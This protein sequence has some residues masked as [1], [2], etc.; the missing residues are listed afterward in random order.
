MK[1]TV[2]QSELLAALTVASKGLSK[3]ASETIL[4]NS[5][6]IRAETDAITIQATDLTKAISFTVPAIVEED[7]GAIFPAA[8]INGIA[9]KLPDASIKI[10]TNTDDS[11]YLT[12]DTIVYDIK[13][14]DARDFPAFP[15]VEPTQ[16]ISLPYPVFTTM[17]K[18]VLPATGKDETRQLLTGVLIEVENK[19]LKMVATD[20]FRLAV[21]E[22]SLPD[23]EGDDYHVVIAGE[24]LKELTALP[25]SEEPI[26]IGITENQVVIRHQKSVFVNRR[27][28]GN[29]PNYKMLLQNEFST[30]VIINRDEFNAALGRVSIVSNS[31]SAAHIVMDADGNIMQVASLGQEKGSAQQ[32]INC[33]IKGENVTA[34]YNFKYLEDGLSVMPTETVRFCVQSPTKPA[35]LYATGEDSFLYLLMPMRL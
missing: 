17:V 34:G 24:F 7:G 4:S 6:L 22:M 15:V 31:S 32:T 25:K 11:A 28:A 8:V 10:T 13:T 3:S 21:T 33:E 27:I 19:T 29:Y 18:Q 35:T 5:L 14:L 26:T 30:E 1:F 20:S 23:Y 12:C 9:K 2:N 16:E